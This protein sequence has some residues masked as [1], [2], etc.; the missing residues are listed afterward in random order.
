MVSAVVSNC[1][2]WQWWIQTFGYG[3]VHH[4]VFPDIRLEGGQ[5]NMFPSISRLFLCWIGP[6]SIAKLDVGHGR[7]SPLWIRHWLLMLC[8]S[9]RTFFLSWNCT[10]CCI[11]KWIPFQFQTLASR[12]ALLRWLSHA[13]GFI[14][15]RRPSVKRCHCRDLCHEL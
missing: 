15:Q 9:W 4:V 5:F 2:C 8:F 11:P 12:R 3:G 7:N 1:N 13:S 6:K 14:W 10:T